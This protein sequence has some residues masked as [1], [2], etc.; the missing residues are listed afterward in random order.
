MFNVPERGLK[1]G[2]STRHATLGSSMDYDGSG[3]QPFSRTSVGINR[4]S[5]IV[6]RND[7]SLGTCP[8]G[9]E[10]ISTGGSNL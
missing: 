10:R 1:P 4:K 7:L 8:G 6:S 9:F 3:L 2:G 5:E